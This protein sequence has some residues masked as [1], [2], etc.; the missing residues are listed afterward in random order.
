MN[1]STDE[2]MSSSISE[3]VN[4]S[5]D[6]SLSRRIDQSMNRSFSETHI[7]SFDES[8]NRCEQKTRTKV[9]D[10]WNHRCTP[11]GVYWEGSRRR[12]K[13]CFRM[14]CLFGDYVWVVEVGNNHGLVWLILAMSFKS[15]FR[16]RALNH[17]LIVNF[18]SVSHSLPMLA[19]V[20][21]IRNQT[22]QLVY[23]VSSVS[24]FE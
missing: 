22:T 24:A 7:W 18:S 3:S 8:M 19:H 10:Y 1:R 20:V 2:S 14:L 17:V 15:N 23:F 11:D 9:K 6:E 5:T 12:L 13:R 21:L 16:W 4:W